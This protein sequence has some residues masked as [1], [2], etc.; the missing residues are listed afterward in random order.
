MREGARVGKKR[1]QGD[2][3]DRPDKPDQGMDGYFGAA[4][5][6]DAACTEDMYGYGRHDMYMYMYKAYCDAKR[7]IDNN[8]NNNSTATTQWSK[9]FQ[10]M[11]RLQMFFYMHS[12]GKQTHHR[13]LYF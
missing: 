12:A 13:L 9:N 1:Q 7:N 4:M 8:N 5:M 11:M 6:N 3:P 10:S 2:R